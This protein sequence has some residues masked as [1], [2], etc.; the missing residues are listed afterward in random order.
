MKR[1]APFCHPRWP[2]DKHFID[3]EIK[4]I[5]SYKRTYFRQGWNIFEWFSY[6]CIL[7]LIVTRVVAVMQDS[8]KPNTTESLPFNLHTNAFPCVLL[9]IWLRFMRSCRPFKGLGVFIAILSYV[10]VATLKFAFLFFE[11]YIPYVVGF[12]IMFGGDEHAKLMGAD[13]IDWRRFNDLLYSVWQ[14]GTLKVYLF[15]LNQY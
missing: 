10:I 7:L 4:Q 8:S 11:F 1:D 5:R 6:A 3:S 15:I 9:V 13:A 2:E 14:V 12:W